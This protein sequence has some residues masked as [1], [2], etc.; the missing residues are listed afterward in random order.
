MLTVSGHYHYIPEEFSIVLHAFQ[1]GLLGM[2]K[3]K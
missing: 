2:L 3:I 1:I